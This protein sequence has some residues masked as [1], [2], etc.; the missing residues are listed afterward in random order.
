MMATASVLPTCFPLSARAP[1][2]LPSRFTCGCLRW[3]VAATP[4]LAICRA[5]LVHSLISP[6]SSSAT[7]AICVNRKRPM[8]PTGNV[9]VNY[10]QWLKKSYDCQ[11]R[12]PARGTAFKKDQPRFQKGP[13]GM[14]R[15]QYLHH[16]PPSPRGL[17]VCPGS[18]SLRC[19]QARWPQTATTRPAW[20]A[21]G[22]VSGGERREGLIRQSY[23]AG[24]GSMRIAALRDHL[25][26]KS[27][28][29]K[30][31]QSLS[32]NWLAIALPLGW[33]AARLI[34]TPG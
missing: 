3:P 13:S 2:G 24:S 12:T 27:A 8:A 30:S 31:R 21:H 11:T 1:L 17:P 5:A 10:T 7:D 4:P 20:G 22:E 6:A 34:E 14:E 33:G 19:V 15:G 26:D 25:A 16:A 28:L 29:W 9:T 18:A 23:T 32:A